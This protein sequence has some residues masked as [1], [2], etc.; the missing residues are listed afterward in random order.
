VR[1]HV[2]YRRA[3]SSAHAGRLYDALAE[4]FGRDQVFVDI[5][6]VQ[7]G[8]DFTDVI[9]RT[10]EESDV[11]LVVIGRGWLHST[12]AQGRRRLENPDDFVRLELERALDRNIPVIPVL[13]QGASM[14]SPDELPSSI[15]GL[16]DR[17]ALEL[18]DVR[19]HQGVETL[20]NALEGIGHA[21]PEGSAEVVP[22]E[23][24]PAHGHAFV[25]YASEDRPEV[26]AFVDRL[27][28]RSIPVWIDDGDIDAALLWGEVIV[29]AIE[30]CAAF[31]VMLSEAA[32]A[33]NNVVREIV[34][35]SEFSKPIVPLLLEPVEVPRSMRY[36]LAG[37]HRIDLF[38]HDENENLRRVLRS[39][40]RIGL[41][42]SPVAG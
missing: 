42:A 9:D 35:A 15:R 26:F 34:L 10:L 18:S 8:L 30:H 28:E 23:L 33:S 19:W 22:Q 3:D 2:T 6:A 21:T 41:S 1:V 32:A 38:A 12:D 13:V 39:L 14:P 31:V 25:S 29:E 40:Q 16:A 20:V 11:V 5:D 37:I 7:P 36:Q 27:R 4:R 17:Q 24:A